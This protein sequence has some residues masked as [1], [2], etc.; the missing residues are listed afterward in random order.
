MWAYIVPLGSP[1]C[2]EDTGVI[3]LIRVQ[4]HGNRVQFS[5]HVFSDS[6]VSDNSTLQVG[7]ANTIVQGSN[8]YL[9]PVSDVTGAVCMNIWRNLMTNTRPCLLY[10]TN[11]PCT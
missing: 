3:G 4:Q 7:L 6:A 2:Q 10:A 1:M 8:A 5:K 11:Q 9:L